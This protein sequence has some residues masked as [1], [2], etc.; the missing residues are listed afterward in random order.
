MTP[1]I[2]VTGLTRRYRDHLAL[3][4]VSL[5][6][7]AGSIIGL[8][9]RNGAGKT[10]LLRIL[11]GQEFPS[12]GGVLVHGAR[13]GR[14]RGGAA[15][16]GVR[17]GGP[18][19][20]R[21]QGPARAAGRVVVLPELERRAGG[22]PAGRLRAARRPGGQEAVPRDAVGARDRDRPGR[23]G[24]GDPV[25]RAL[26]GPRRGGQADLLRPAAGRLCRA[27]PHDPAL[28]PPDRRGGRAARAGDRDRPGPDRAHGRRRRPAR[29]RHRRERAGP[30]GGRVHRR[31]G[32]L[33]PAAGG[34][35]GLGRRRRRARRGRPR[36]GPARC[37]WICRR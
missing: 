23:P 3:D 27:S 10:T 34:L 33:G 37:T 5:E 21:L 13:A 11:A 4:Q 29:R 36:C 20:P 6:V 2:S 32:G 18:D 30:G 19:L 17:P 8:L 7:E 14:E 15:P 16:D 31:P 1:A 12:A 28:H 9:G 22:R 25:R 35:A 24:G 26:R